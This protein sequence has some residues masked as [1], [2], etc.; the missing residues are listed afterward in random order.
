MLD[1][2]VYFS[3]IATMIDIPIQWVV[4]IKT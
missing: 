1:D 4:P 2:A 3:A